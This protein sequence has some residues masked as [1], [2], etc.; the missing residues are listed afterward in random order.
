[1][2]R[3]YMEKRGVF[4]EDISW[5]SPISCNEKTYTL[6]GLTAN[7]DYRVQVRGKYGSEN[8]SPWVTKAFTTTAPMPG[9]ANGDGEV[10]VTDIMAVANF[11][12]GIDMTTFYEQAADVNGDD[13]VNVTDIMGIANIIL[14]VNTSSSRVVRKD[15]TLEPQ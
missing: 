8:Y 4:D 2:I 14:G 7:T 9:D 13:D 1:M 10:N 6:T 3:G 5:T 11:I 12:L 15:E